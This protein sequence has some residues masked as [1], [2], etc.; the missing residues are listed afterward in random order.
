[1]DE[2]AVSFEDNRTT[3]VDETGSRHVAVRFTGFASICVTVALAV[4]AT[5]QKLSPW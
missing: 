1:M 3:T 2:R 4:A 5:E